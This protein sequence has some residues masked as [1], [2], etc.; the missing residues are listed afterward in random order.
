MEPRPHLSFCAS[1]IAWLASELLV[2]IGPS[3]YL[4]FLHAKQRVLEQNYKS[5]RSQTSP[6][7]LCMQNSVISIRIS[8]L[9][10]SHLSSVVFTYKTAR[11]V[12]EILVSMGYRPFLSFCACKTAT[13][14]PDLQVCMGP[15]PHLRLWALITACLAQEQKGYIGSR[16]HLWFCASKTATLGLELQIS[17][18]PRPHLWIVH[19]KQR[20]LD[21][22]NKSLCFPH[23]TCHFVHV[24][25]RA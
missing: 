3:P 12:P 6:V 17:V 1:K 5:L 4:W 25:E 14:G 10:G 15:R 13:L 9:Y 18:G 7:V 24:Q 20:L 21:L 11:Y 2:S 22:N 8:S 23:M 16:P 19:A